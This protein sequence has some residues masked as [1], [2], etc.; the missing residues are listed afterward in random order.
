MNFKVLINGIDYTKYVPIPFDIQNALDES[1]DIGFIRLLYLEREKPFSPFDTILIEIKDN[2]E[3]SQEFSFFI[4]TDVVTEIISSN[5][6]N[7]ELSLIEQTKWLERFTGIVKTNTTSLYKD[8]KSAEQYIPIMLK[9]TAGNIEVPFS[10]L[11]EEK[12]TEVLDNSYHNPYYYVTPQTRTILALPGFDMLTEDLTGSAFPEEQFIKYEVLYKDKVIKTGTNYSGISNFPISNNKGKYEIR[13][14]FTMDNQTYYLSI[15]FGAVE[16][17]KPTQYTINNVIN[18]LLLTFECLYEDETPRFQLN[19]TQSV[20]FE[21][22]EAPD[23]SL[24][25]TLWECL[26]QIGNFLHA[27]PR[28][29]NN[30]LYFDKLGTS[31]ETPIDLSNYCSSSSRFDIEQFASAIDSTVDNIVNVDEKAQGSITAPFN[32]GFKTVRSE[33]GVVQLTSDNILIET[34]EPIEEIISVECGYISDN[35]YVGDITPYIFENAEYNALSA[36][37]GQFPTSRA[38]ALK[39]TQGQKN[40]TGLNF[41]LPNA[42]SEV[43]SRY[44]IINIIARKL[45]ISP[46][47]LA[48]ENI[49]KL[50]FRVK[51]IPVISARMKQTKSN[52]EDIIHI[53]NLDFNQSANKINSFA[54]GENMKGTIA[55]LGNPELTKVYLL[56]DLSKIPEVGNLFNDDYYISIVKTEFYKEFCKCEIALSKNFNRLNEYVGIN[57]QKRFYEISEKQSVDRHIV[58]ED[59]CVIGDNYNGDNKSLINSEGIKKFVNQFLNTTSNNNIDIVKCSGYSDVEHKL[60]TVLLPVN[61]IGV[62]NSILFN[63]HYDDNYSAGNVREL[64]DNTELQYQVRYTDLLGRVDKLE[65]DFGVGNS[66]I[67]NYSTAISEGNNFPIANDNL[68]TSYFS[69]NGNKLIIKKDNREN[70]YFTY[71]LNFI[72]TDKSFVLG[73]SLTRKSIFVSTDTNKYK[74]YV[75]PNKLNKFERFVDISNATLISESFTGYTINGNTVS[76]PAFKST[77]NGKAW[78]IIDENNELVIG[79]NK[80]INEN[81]EISAVNFTFTHKII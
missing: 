80:N 63:F 50:Q 79:Q 26:S 51:Y 61:S 22:I 13:Y 66:Q 1:L 68:I 77:I 12:T 6:F 75:L 39:Y 65:I 37:G 19:E 34:R 71:Q 44:S 52:L 32:N 7:H 38:Y 24:I 53:S 14:Y 21:K 16:S 72:T 54:Y 23:F 2:L 59:F 29:Q 11:N 31:K 76:L 48:N 9:N 5:K 47:S 17:E 55:K 45:Q 15:V 40:I 78:V 8:L 67:T 64:R 73:S 41:K 36:T 35:R 56:N 49:L 58:F 69:T 20:E 43:F 3:N 46:S 27:I 60:E 81:N 42:V 57:S 25:G 33:T 30:V 62:G 28:L 18:N 10:W 74:L 4:A 70:I